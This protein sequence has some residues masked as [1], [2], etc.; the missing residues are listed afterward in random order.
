MQQLSILMT[1]DTHGFWP[2]SENAERSLLNT[3]ATIK[4]L[5][6]KG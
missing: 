3:A 5:E 1:S 4:K 6:R 2:N